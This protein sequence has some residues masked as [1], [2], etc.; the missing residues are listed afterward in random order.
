MA[1][2]GPRYFSACTTEVS[3]RA[4]VA[5]PASAGS[6]AVTI[7]LSRQPLA[8]QTQSPGS[9]PSAHDSTTSPTAQMSSIG[10]FN[11]KELK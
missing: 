11:G 7:A 1:P 3:I 6:P 2:S 8:R 4:S 9:K 10:A 5:M